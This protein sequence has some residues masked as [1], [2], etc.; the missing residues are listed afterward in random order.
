M[1]GDQLSGDQF[2]QHTAE[3]VAQPGRVPGSGVR[4]R[5]RRLQFR[6]LPGSPQA[7]SRFA[8]I[9]RVSSSSKILACQVRDGG[10]NPPTRSRYTFYGET[11]E[12]GEPRWSVKPEPPGCV[13][14]NP[15]LSTRAYGPVSKHNKAGGGSSVAEQETSL[16][17][18]LS[19]RLKHG[20]R[21][22][23]GGLP[24]LM[25]GSWVRVPPAPPRI[26]QHIDDVMR[27]VAQW[28]SVYL[29]SAPTCLWSGLAGS[30]PKR[31]A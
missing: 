21:A 19:S 5:S 11:A 17:H 26:F 9:K 29:P 4:L 25:A 27:T 12:A 16:Q 15:T 6:V 24:L 31:E 10:A 7:E 18:T 14:S 8:T 28:Q 30:R 2:P 1:S 22:E 20:R 23:A 3:S 13:G